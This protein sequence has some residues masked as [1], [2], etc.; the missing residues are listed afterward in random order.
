MSTLGWILGGT[1]LMALIAWVGLAMLA[2]RG[3][4]LQRAL[5]ALVAFT[6]GSLLGGAFL[7]L[8]PEAL[9]RTGPVIEPFLWLLVGF[10][11]FFI[12][13]Q[14]LHWRHD[15]GVRSFSHQPVTYLILLADGVHNF[16]GGL[17]IGGSFLAGP[18]IGMVTWLAAAAHEI[19][20]ELGDFAILV[21]GGWPARRALLCNFASALTIVP[22]GLLAFL[23]GTAVDTTFLLP[24]AA[25]NFVYI[26]ASDLIPE[27]KHG[28]GG[29]QRFLH[30]AAFIAGILAILAA[31]L[32]FD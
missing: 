29:C 23:A 28:D 11:I 2:L 30:L 4:S 20:Q 9:V 31:M 26:A 17:A 14:F 13:E 12:L 19:P 3:E 22:G 21:R 32:L 1:T 16:L 5:P 27:I 10:L 15:H 18:R 24:L 8:M 25:G 7:H 6:A